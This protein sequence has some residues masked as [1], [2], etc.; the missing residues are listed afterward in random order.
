MREF[1]PEQVCEV[2]TGWIQDRVCEAGARGVVVGLSGG[3]DSAVTAVLAKKAF[4]ENVLGVL[5]PCESNP[6][7]AEDAWLV[8]NEF[9]IP[10]QTVDLGPV[11]RLLVSTLDEAGS[12]SGSAVRPELGREVLARANTKP[13]LRMIT[14]YYFANRLNYLVAGTGNRSELTVGYFTKYGDGGVDLL[15]IGGLVKQQVRA[16]ARYLGIPGDLITK[17]PSAG[18]WSGQ[19]DE[20]EMGLSYED[21]D[22]YITSGEGEP[23]IV[24]R[25][26]TLN[27][28][29]EHK[30][31]MPPVPDL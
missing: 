10:T 7:D 17:A 6:K 28:Q 25:I 18:L 20:G 14:L 31:N 9:A 4:P 1:E 5:M 8:A 19:T 3:I 12:T 21:L 23:E 24:S 15:P 26:Q 29:S 11:F 2:V 22:E 13:R 16:L 30:R 27:R